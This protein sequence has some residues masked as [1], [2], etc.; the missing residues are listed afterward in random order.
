MKDKNPFQ[1]A[2]REAMIGIILVVFN[3]IWWFAFAYGLGDKSPEDYQFIFGFPAWF[4]YSCIVGV[5]V[6]AI[7]VLVTVKF[8][9]KDV[10]LDEKEF[11]QT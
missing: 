5:F 9:F 3:F 2:N 7:L 11:D 8:L 6:M 10:S 1:I 4:F